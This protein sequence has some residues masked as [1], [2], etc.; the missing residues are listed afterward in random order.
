[1]PSS[2]SSINRSSGSRHKWPELIVLD[3]SQP[4]RTPAAVEEASAAQSV[5][6]PPDQARDQSNFEGLGPVEAG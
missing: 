2:L 5:R 4:N 3:T 6:F 1:L